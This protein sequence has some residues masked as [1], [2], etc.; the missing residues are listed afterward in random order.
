MPIHFKVHMKT[1]SS[2]SD[3]FTSNINFLINKTRHEQLVQ[4]C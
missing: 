4:K 3:G 1:F 2:L